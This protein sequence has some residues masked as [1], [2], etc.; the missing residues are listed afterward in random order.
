LG[1]AQGVGFV[2]AWIVVPLQPDTAISG[3]GLLLLLA[4]VVLIGAG[5]VWLCWRALMTWRA[6]SP[7]ALGRLY[8]AGLLLLPLGALDPTMLLFTPA[9]LLLV[10]GAAIARNRV[11]LAERQQ[12]AHS[13]P[14]DGS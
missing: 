11:L 4:L 14:P 5:T 7:K 9:G 12:R 1:L 10:I 6:R 13:D 2:L 8:L 3:G